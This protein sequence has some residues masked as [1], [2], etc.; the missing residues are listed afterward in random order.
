M[1]LQAKSEFTYDLGVLFFTEV[2]WGE[3]NSGFVK[4]L[5]TNKENKF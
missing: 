3:K 4:Q 1:S 5:F 2:K